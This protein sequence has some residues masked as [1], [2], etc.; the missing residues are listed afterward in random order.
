MSSPSK[1]VCNFLRLLIR[2][3]EDTAGI[4]RQAV[5]TFGHIKVKIT[6]IGTERV[7]DSSFWSRCYCTMSRDDVHIISLVFGVDIEFRSFGSIAR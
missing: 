2:L 6:T 7:F 4:I 1:R 3:D 5:L